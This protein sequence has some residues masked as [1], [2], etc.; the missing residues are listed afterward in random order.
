MKY[1]ISTLGIFFFIITYGI[2]QND[3]LQVDLE[4]V[5]IK[6]R[7]MEIGYSEM[8]RT[9][10]LIT[11]DDIKFLPAQSLPELLQNVAGIDVRRRGVNG[12][13]ADL[14]IRGG[15]FDQSLVLVNGIN[16]SDPQTGHHLMNIP[17]N[18]EDIE[19]IEILKGPGA[20]VYGQNAFAG[21]INIVTKQKTKSTASIFTSYAQNET[22]RIGVSASIPVQNGSHQFTYAKSFSEGY[23]YNT[24]YEVDNIWYQSQFDI[25]DDKLMLMAGYTSRAFGANGFYASPSFTDQYEEIGTSL[26]SAKYEHQKN[27][28]TLRPAFFWR[29]NQ[30]EYIFVRSNPSI[31]RN[32]HIGNALGLEL[33]ATNVNEY[34]VL[35]I[36]LESRIDYLQSNNLGDRKRATFGINIEQRLVFFDILDITPGVA[37]FNYSDFGSRLFPGIDLGMA[38]TDRIRIYANIGSTWRV[39]TYTDLFYEDPA[40]LG[41][42]ELKPERALTAEMGFRFQDRNWDLQMSYFARHSENL[43]DWTKVNDDDPWFPSNVGEVVIRGIE[44]NASVDPTNIFK[45]NLP[46]LTFGYAHFSGENEGDAPISRYALE[47][48]RNHFTMGVN[49]SWTDKFYNTLLVKHVDRLTL[50][51]YTLIDAKIGLKV[52]KIDFALFSNNL[53]DRDYT[54]TN[55]VPMPGRWSGVEVNYLIT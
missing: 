32:L 38:F 43:I 33:N 8:S 18:V 39:P 40:N 51:N 2:S 35:G 1:F 15:G 9:I 30:D 26:L 34:G 16:L 49:M 6:D 10:Q 13:Q 50:E 47:Y 24:D 22:A 27:N 41:N 28:W 12:V 25:G 23:R 29:R 5:M 36:G 52:K 17:V 14:S 37:I 44:L 48:I 46:S 42:S 45:V 31:Y 3:S 11:A 55:L 20:R 7:R 4:E 54:E 19:R 53:L 21:A